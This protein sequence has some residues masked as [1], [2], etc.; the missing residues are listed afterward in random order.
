MAEDGALTLLK[1]TRY[2]SCVLTD[3]DPRDKFVIVGVRSD[4]RSAICPI[5]IKTLKTEEEKVKNA[6]LNKHVADSSPVA[7]YY[8]TG[9]APSKAFDGDLS[10]RASTKLRAGELV[11]TVDLGG[12]YSLDDLVINEYNTSSTTYSPETT[13]EYSPDCGYTWVKVIDKQPLNTPL[14]P[15]TETVFKNLGVILATSVRFTFNN[16]NVDNSNDPALSRRTAN[17]NEIEWSGTRLPDDAVNKLEAQTLLETLDSIDQSRFDE[18]RLDDINNA[19][20]CLKKLFEIEFPD[21]ELLVRAINV[22]KCI[23]HN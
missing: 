9:M 2:A 12:R 11:F 7:T 23:I 16:N 8:S 15:N 18:K 21:R 19:K 5:E 17:I 1:T 14:A 3:A 13:V 20:D 10:T 22:I 6:L 4:L